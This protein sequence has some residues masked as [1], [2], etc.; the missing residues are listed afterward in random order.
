MPTSISADPS[1]GRACGRGPPRGSG[2]RGCCL[3][4]SIL[5]VI[6]QDKKSGARGRAE[7]QKVARAGFLRGKRAQQ[8]W[9]ARPCEDNKSGARSFFIG[10]RAP[11]KWRAQVRETAHTG[12]SFK[13]NGIHLTL[14]ARCQASNQST[15]SQATNQK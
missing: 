12:C 5:R 7:T 6:E 14:N 1:L 11:K 9:R 3:L 10:N 4:G 2:D 13:C 8:K 15:N